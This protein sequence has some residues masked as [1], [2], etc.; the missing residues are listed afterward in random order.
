MG[1]VLQEEAREDEEGV[2]ICGLSTGSLDR[3]MEWN[4]ALEQ[5]KEG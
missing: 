1:S 5:S 3:L 2:I 4:L